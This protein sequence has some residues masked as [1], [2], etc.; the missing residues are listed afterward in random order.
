MKGLIYTYTCTYL[1]AALAIFYPLL[2]LAL[3]INFAIVQPPSMWYWIVPAKNYSEIIGGAM[4]IGWALKGFGDWRLGR[5]Q[6]VVYCFFAYLF[7]AILCTVQSP[8]PPLGWRYVEST[9]KILIP[10]M[11]G[12]TLIDNSAKLRF[13][14]WALTI[15]QGYVAYEFNLSYY[16]G[17]NRM[18]SDE[19][20]GG[21][22]NNYLAVAMVTG[23]G[24]A[25][26]LGMGE[27]KWYMKAFAFLCFALM[28]H[29]VMFSFSRGGM[30]A[31]IITGVV[32]FLLINKKP[33]HIVMFGLALL[34]CLRLAGPQ[35]RERFSSVFV[36]PEERDASTTSRLDS[37]KACLDVMQKKP[38]LGVGPNHWRSIAGNYGYPNLEAHSLWLQAG[39]ELGIPGL[40][41]L[42]GFYGFCMAPLLPIALG[43]GKVPDPWFRDV[44]RMVIASLVGF[45]IAAQFVSIS[46]LEL[47]Y[48]VVAAGAA[49]LRLSSVPSR[50]PWGAVARPRPFATPLM[51]QGYQ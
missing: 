5:A 46:G 6:A 44:A 49:V 2:G 37:W 40:A 15:S 20:F 30:L 11:V 43:R 31:L 18:C 41:F 14:L 23:C 32:A 42:L 12:L 21:M 10:F 25:F 13:F 1:G 26:F 50:E 9:F 38:V 36:D 24:I 3:F 47:P 45:M 28:A 7:W 51:A 34:L 16:A 48:Y 19:G 17:I 27:R 35:V 29:C 33:R 4:L 22:D 39:A 8:V